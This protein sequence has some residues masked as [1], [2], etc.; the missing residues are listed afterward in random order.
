MTTENT[1]HEP[2]D[3]FGGLL[4]GKVAVITGV[5]AAETIGAVTAAVFV[6]EGAQVLAA[7]I[8]GAQKE[9][10]LALGPGVVP[11]QVDITREEEVEAMFARAVEVFGRV[12]ILVNV[13]GNPGGRRGD[14]ITVEEYQSLTSVHLLGTVLTNKHAVR[15]MTPNGGGAI[16]NFSSAASFNTDKLIS[17]AYAAAKAGI[18]SLTKSNA[19]HHG[20]QNIRVNAVAPGFTMSKKNRGLPPA[21]EE[22]LSNKAALARPGTPEE[23][24]HVA[25]FLASDRASFVTGVVVPVDGGWTAKLA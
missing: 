24:A 7:D 15:V 1:S 23:Q 6:K 20:P 25:A 11:F 22:S 17:T 12:D 18:N 5:G 14:E 19:V 21:I 4:E 16:V 8:S 10:A 3:R 13:A 9:T 2:I